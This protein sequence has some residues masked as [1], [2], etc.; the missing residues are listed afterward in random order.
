[1]HTKSDQDERLLLTVE[2][3]GDLTGWGRSFLYGLISRGE[4]PSLK[5][6]RTR[7]VARRSI[8]EFIERQLEQVSE[9]AG[10]SKRSYSH[11]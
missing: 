2:E 8:E 11:P 5:V 6:G 4:L 3:C 9:S 7:R 10:P 1:M